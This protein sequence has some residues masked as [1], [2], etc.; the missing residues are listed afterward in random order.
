M[1]RVVCVA[2]GALICGVFCYSDVF[3]GEP[4]RRIPVFV[5][6]LATTHEL[7]GPL[8][9]P[10][11][12][13]MTVVMTVDQPELK[14]EFHD[15]VTVTT[16]N[17]FILRKP[18]SIPIRMWMFGSNLVESKPSREGEVGDYRWKFKPGD[19]ITVRAYQDGAMVGLPE[20]AMKETVFAQTQAH[21]FET[22]LVP[23]NE[24]RSLAK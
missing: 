16:V 3:T 7:I 9:R 19:T 1:R 4:I 17:G 10:L 11:S 2:I 6:S 24:V 14:G 15:F 12:E 5:E 23:V 21:R 20:Q 13:M 18:V 8:G 22:W